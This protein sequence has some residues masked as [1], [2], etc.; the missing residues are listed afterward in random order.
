[1]FAELSV[2][3]LF[4]SYSLIIAGYAASCKDYCNNETV[5]EGDLWEME[6]DLRSEEK[7]KRTLHWF[8]R[9]KQQKG[10]FKGLPDRVQFGVCHFILFIHSSSFSSDMHI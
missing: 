1:M 9:G 6:V 10:F 4:K 8:V 7:E 3:S 5:N 2:T